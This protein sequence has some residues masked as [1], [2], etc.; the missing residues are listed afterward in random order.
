MPGINRV[1]NVNSATTDPLAHKVLLK[2]PPTEVILLPK[3]RY[4]VRIVLGGDKTEF[5]F[6]LCLFDTGAGP[7]IIKEA[8]I[9]LHWK[10]SNKPLDATEL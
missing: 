9:S 10:R 4:K 5:Y 2:V 6:I 7:N 8:Y 3:D 1:E